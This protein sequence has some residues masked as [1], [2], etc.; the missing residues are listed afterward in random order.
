[1][2]RAYLST[3]A[4]TQLSEGVKTMAIV[5]GPL[6][7]LDARGKFANALVFTA[8][9]GRAVVRQLVIPANPFAALQVAVRNMV[10][11]TGAGQ[12]FANLATTMGAGRTLTDKAELQAVAPSGQSWNG[13][14]VKAMIGAGEVNYD[15]ASTAWTAL[16]GG[17]QTAWDTAA[18]GLTPAIPAVAQSVAGGGAGTPMTSGEVFFHYTYGLYVLGISAAPSAVPPVYA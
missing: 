18:D 13:T 4:P 6:M 17:E 14:L 9:K 8:W 10:R 15:A 12:H 3:G 7:S 5:S 1:V 16:T 2:D 11:A